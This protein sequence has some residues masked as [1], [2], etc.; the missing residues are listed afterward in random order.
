MMFL[1]WNDVHKHADF[2]QLTDAILSMFAEGCTGLERLTL[3]EPTATGVQSDCL[4]QPGWMARQGS[5]RQNRQR[6]L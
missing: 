2:R 4:I 6:L 3:S 1:D 5:W